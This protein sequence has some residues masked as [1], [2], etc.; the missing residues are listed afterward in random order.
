[1]KFTKLI[2]AGS[3]D[4]NDYPLLA[5]TMDRLYPVSPDAIISG[6][7]RGADK[8]GERY[9]KEHDIYLIQ[10]PADWD[11]YGKRAGY[12]RNEE[13][14]DMATH[15]LLFWDGESKGTKHMRDISKKHNLV[16]DVINT[17]ETY[18]PGVEESEDNQ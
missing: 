10:V 14:A 16:V 17:S 2:I 4:F 9:A 15:V 11:R 5:A 1:M 13:M 6:T 18:T 7:A 8:L 12:L 3:R